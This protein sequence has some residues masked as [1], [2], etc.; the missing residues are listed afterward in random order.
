MSNKE[1]ENR[2][3]V[4][5]NDHILKKRSLSINPSNDVNKNKSEPTSKRFKPLL[6]CVVCN[7]DAHGM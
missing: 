4:K 3:Q 6:T 1:S 7:G 2:L 5:N